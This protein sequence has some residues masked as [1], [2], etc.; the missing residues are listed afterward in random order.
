MLETE[1]RCRVMNVNRSEGLLVEA[2]PLRAAEEICRRLVDR[3]GIANG[4]LLLAADPTWAG[5]INTVLVK[6]G[7][8]VDELRRVEDSQVISKLGV[9]TPEGDPHDGCTDLH[10]VPSFTYWGGIG[11]LN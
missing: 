5:A 4:A 3:V 2:E 11:T 6:K 9:P 7:V 10:H 8:R 1:R